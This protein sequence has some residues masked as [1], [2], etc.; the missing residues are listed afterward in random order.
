MNRNAL[1]VIIVVGILTLSM[2]SAVSFKTM[3]VSA[4]SFRI[5]FQN[6]DTVSGLVNNLIRFTV[7]VEECVSDTSCKAANTAPV[8]WSVAEAS[9]GPFTTIGQ[10]GTNSDG[11]AYIGYNFSNAG[12]HTVMA[13]VPGASDK[14]EVNIGVEDLG[15]SWSVVNPLYVPQGCSWNSRPTTGK[16]GD[17]LEFNLQVGP[18]PPADQRSGSWG[19]SGPMTG[20]RVQEIKDNGEFVFSFKFEKAGQYYVTVPA[21]CGMGAWIVDISEAGGAVKTSPTDESNG[22]TNGGSGGDSAATSTSTA[23]ATA[24][25]QT[26]STAKS[27][28]LTPGFEF[29]G[30]LAGLVLVALFMVNK[31]YR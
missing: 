31:R 6:P 30:A 18:V 21:V 22:N 8:T 5:N 12:F 17:M 11:I 29:I 9:T 7:K 13:V 16:V 25:N 3:P 15:P 14:V 20:G 28:S 4:G 1:S 10:S 23:N 27:T 19:I 26:S 24:L 2:F